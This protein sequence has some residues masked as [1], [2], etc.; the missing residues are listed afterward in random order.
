MRQKN[1]LLKANDAEHAAKQLKIYV[2][3]A[4]LSME[5]YFDMSVREPLRSQTLDDKDFD[6]VFS[7][8]DGRKEA[9]TA[10]QNSIQSLASY[11]EN[12]MPTVSE[13]QADTVDLSPLCEFGGAD[14]AAGGV[15]AEVNKAVAATIDDMKQ[16]TIW[17][18]KWH[19]QE[20]M[21]DEIA[22]EY[23]AAGEPKGCVRS[24]V[25]TMVLM[26][27]WQIG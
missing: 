22:Q 15:E 20:G 14:A 17:L 21:T 3:K 12:E 10:V 4:M 19:N 8:S 23:V 5:Y 7:P 6:A 2:S 13:Q 25:F 16:A 18:Q 27:I 24:S 26:V 11:C 1:L 9:S